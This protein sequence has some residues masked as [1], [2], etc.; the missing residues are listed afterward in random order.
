MLTQG[1]M[2][3]YHSVENRQDN[4]LLNSHELGMFLSADSGG[5]PRGWLRD[6]SDPA[7]K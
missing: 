6:E 2:E 4:L 1:R 3:A 7:V 5:F